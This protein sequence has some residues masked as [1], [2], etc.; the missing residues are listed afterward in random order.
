M[1][2]K[3]ANWQVLLGIQP[4]TEELVENTLWKGILTAVKGRYPFKED[5]WTTVEKGI[6]I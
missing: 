1:V 6:H 3:P 4:L 2:K 5:E